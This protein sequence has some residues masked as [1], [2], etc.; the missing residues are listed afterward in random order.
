MTSSIPATRAGMEN[1]VDAP[2]PVPVAADKAVR[3]EQEQAN[4]EAEK[5]TAAKVAAEKAAAATAAVTIVKS[6]AKEKV[7]AE[8][9]ASSIPATQ[10]EVKKTVDV[11]TVTVTL[12]LVTT[13]TLTAY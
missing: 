7:D 5:A 2:Q 1:K 3:M 9:G 10:L 12:T 8:K 4:E 13:L 6:E 11:P